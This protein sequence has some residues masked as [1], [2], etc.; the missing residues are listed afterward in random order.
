MLFKYIVHYG[1]SKNVTSYLQ[2]AGRIGR[3][4]HEAYNV[5]VYRGRHLIT[6]EPDIKA[7]VWK[8]LTSCCHMAL[9]ESFDDEICSVSPIMCATKA[10]NMR[11]L[12]AV[13]PFQT[14]IDWQ[15]MTC[16]QL[17]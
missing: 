4:G 3:D 12:D 7:A 5:T 9:L 2:E 14:L 6:C 15:T 11:I 17:I 16:T 13:N 8:S 10:T 1:P